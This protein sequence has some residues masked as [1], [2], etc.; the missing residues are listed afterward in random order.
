MTGQSAT[1]AIAAGLGLASLLGYAVGFRWAAARAGM[2]GYIAV[3]ALLFVVYLL[4][5]WVVLQRAS[6]DRIVLGM[7]LG[8]ALLFRLV[9]VPTP[10]L[11]SSDPYRY[12]WDG[13]VQHAGLSPYAY[14]PAAE[15]LAP[16]R[17]REIYPHINRPVKRTVYPP[18]AE[19]LYWAVTAV[20]P[21]SMAA[22]RLFLVGCEGLTLAL[23]IDLLRRLGRPV[24]AV[25]LY[26][27]A[28]LAVFESAQGGH[29]DFA[30]LPLLLLALRLRQEERMGWAGAALGLAVLIKL[31]PAVLLP[32]WWRRGDWRLPAMLVL[33]VAAGYL[34]YLPGAGGHV[35]G[36]LPEYFVARTEDHNI[37]L[38]ALLT[39]GL[40]LAG[41]G[42]RAA[43]M[44]LLF[45][46]LAVVLLWIGR[47]TPDD[48]AGACRAAALS[49]AA[50]LLLVPTAMHPWYVVWLI[51]FLCVWPWPAWVHFSGAVVLSYVS[52][53]VAPAPIPW[54]A[55][56]S[57][58]GPL[59]ALLAVAGGRALAR[60]LRPRLGAAARVT[61]GAR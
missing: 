23:L 13:R 26:A 57:Q 5:A 46:L 24:G 15:E 39:Y 16:L 45:A 53:V 2:V 21:D 43:A 58:Y 28:P 47:T 48:A 20:V 36:F 17:D 42:P 41:D 22:W 37:G 27:W 3:F 61:I 34:G 44:V 33:V 30:L 4:A 60:R 35:L 31:Y 14:P 12:L 32:A 8:G 40:G 19:A 25:V 11:L 7:V 59:Y 1:R 52:Y 56:L 9:L 6:G 50:Y 55:W 38:R 54:W 49:V 51:P 18:G 10:V 29:V